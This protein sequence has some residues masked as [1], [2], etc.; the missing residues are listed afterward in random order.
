MSE[1][2]RREFIRTLGLWV[3]TATVVPVAAAYSGGSKGSQRRSAEETSANPGGSQ[4]KSVTIEP[5][6]NEMKFAQ[7]EIRATAG[8][9]LTIVFDNTATSPA[10]HHNVVVLEPIEGVKETVGT[11]AMTAKQNDYIPPKHTDKIIAH[12][13]MSAP[14]ETVEVTFTVPE[15]GEYPYICTYPGHWTTMQGMLYSEEG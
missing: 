13:P 2:D 1:Q 7:T 8:S 14:G 15:P 5:V 6:G 12:T 4:A 9:E 11:A 10:M 3:G